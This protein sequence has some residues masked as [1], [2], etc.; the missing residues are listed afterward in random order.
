MVIENREYEWDVMIEHEKPALI[1]DAK[2]NG[3]SIA[4]TDTPGLNGTVI[5]IW[6]EDRFFGPGAIVEFDDKRF[7]ARILSEPYQDGHDWVYTLQCADGQA[8][9]FIPPSLLTSGSQLSTAGS[10][11]EEGSDE[12]DIL[13][14]QTPVKLR[15]QLT[16]MRLKYDIT[17]SAVATVMVVAMR[18]PISKKSSFYWADIQEWAAL[19]KWFRTIDY[20]L[21]YDQ[22]NA[23]SNGTVSMRGT[24]GLPVYRGAGLLQ[25]ISPSNKRSYTKLTID[26]LEDFLMDLSY[27]MLGFGER[28]FIALTGEMGMKE[29]DRVLREKASSYS[30]IASFFVTGSGQELTLGGQFTTY[31]FLNGIELTLRHFPLYDEL[32]HNRKLHPVSGKPV[33]SY[34]MTFID[35]GMYDGESNVVKVVRKGR[36]FVVW[37]VAGA[38]APGQKFGINKDTLRAHGGDKYTVNFLG[39]M[40]IMLKNP[41]TSGELILDVDMA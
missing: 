12:A 27:N 15:N 13:N 4:T 37:T 40:G 14:Y 20:Q 6:T 8:E 33:E 17:G 36:E 10:A 26:I 7:Q 32:Y 18:D 31:K 34:R 2:W 25:Q 24:N 9:T 19:R 38:V 29:L 30:L 5:Q 35:F 39:E 21:M 3:A 16:T 1:K 41:T 23:N 28:K 11:Y 22:Y